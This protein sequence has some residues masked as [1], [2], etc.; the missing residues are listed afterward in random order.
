VIARQLLVGLEL[1]GCVPFALAAPA[2]VAPATVVTSG[3]C[4]ASR[5]GRWYASR[6]RQASVDV[7]ELHYDAPVENELLVR[8]V[9]RSLQGDA[10]RRRL[11]PGL[12]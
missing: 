1:R 3:G 9:A 5:D 6:L 4:E 2:D 7:D 11:V 8:D 12:S 10:A